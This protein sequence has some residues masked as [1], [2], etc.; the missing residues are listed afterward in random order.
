MWIVGVIHEFGRKE[1]S[2]VVL[3]FGAV[4]GWNGVLFGLFEILCE[5]FRMF[6]NIVGMGSD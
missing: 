1:C 3:G 6:L 4:F 5:L 2:C